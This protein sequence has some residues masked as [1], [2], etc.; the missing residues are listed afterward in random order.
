M[1]AESVKI[2][3]EKLHI[4]ENNLNRE[5]SKIDAQ[6]ATLKKRKAK[7]AKQVSSN[8]KNRNRLIFPERFT[9]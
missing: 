9:I 3:L 7:I 8:M 2:S 6:I 1:I 5:M 4:R